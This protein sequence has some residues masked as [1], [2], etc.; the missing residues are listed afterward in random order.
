VAKV[1][2]EVSEAA[3]AHRIP[4]KVRAAYLRTRFLDERRHVMKRWAEF[5]SGPNKESRITRPCG[6]SIRELA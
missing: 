1:R 6:A 4:D 2:D 3:L 5:V